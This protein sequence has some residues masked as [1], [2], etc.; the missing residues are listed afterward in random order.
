MRIVHMGQRTFAAAVLDE[1]VR[2]KEDVIAVY[3][4]PDVE[5]RA[6]DPL[7][8]A[9]IDLGIPLLQPPSYRERE[10]LDEF[11]ALRLDL[12]VM[13]FV[14]RFVPPEMLAAPSCGA[15]Q[16]HPSLLPR[17]RGPSS[18]NWPIIW[19][20]AKTGI[21]VFWPDGGLDEGPI[22]LQREVEIKGDDTVG[23][24]YFDRLFP[25]GVEALADAVAMVADGTA[26]R[27]PQDPCKATYETRCRHE[28]V[29]IRWN[30]PSATTWNLI[31]GANPQPG[32][33][34]T[35]GSQVVTVYDAEQVSRPGGTVPGLV[36]D[37]GADGAMVASPDG[38]I[39]LK[40][41]RIDGGPKVPALEAG[42]AVGERLGI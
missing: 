2:R 25:I 16:Y 28:D 3:G 12:L 15:I 40:R 13:A 19:G 24:L 14:T 26:P 38:A 6:P 33:W 29:R 21:S 32:A 35:R 11:A 31:R 8:R 39:L 42:I 36:I 17:H 30:D 4:P 27:I 37:V 20:E 1:L 9:A 18:I 41:V 23:S 7:G 22:L 10:V 34:T 5:D